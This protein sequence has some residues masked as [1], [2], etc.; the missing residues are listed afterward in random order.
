MKLLK[1]AQLHPTGA[2]H[3]TQGL[4]E[5]ERI[6]LGGYIAF[7]PGQVAHEGEVHIS[8]GS[9]VFVA[10]SGKGK[11]DI[12]GIVHDFVAGDVA[13]IAEGE[14][15]HVGWPDDEDPLVMVWYLTVHPPAR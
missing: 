4:V 1:L 3:I 14:D 10:L 5:G 2:G 11:L 12:D 6:E 13:I 9:E 15:H 7:K 8:D